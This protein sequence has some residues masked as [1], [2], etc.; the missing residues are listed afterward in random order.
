VTILAT[1]RAGLSSSFFCFPAYPSRYSPLV[2]IRLD[3]KD[4]CHPS[5]PVPTFHYPPLGEHSDC[6]DS[7]LSSPKLG[8]FLCAPTPPS[9]R[10]Q[11]EQPPP[12]SKSKEV[13]SP[14]RF[15]WTFFLIVFDL[16][17]PPSSP[18]ACPTKIFEIQSVEEAWKGLTISFQVFGGVVSL[19][20]IELHGF[21]FPAYAWQ[22]IARGP[23]RLPSGLSLSWPP[24]IQMTLS[25]LLLYATGFSVPSEPFDSFRS[26]PQPRPLQESFFFF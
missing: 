16:F 24:S 15:G 5:F 17:P 4:H 13:A 14:S 19:W 8:S 10:S 26:N 1:L 2:A 7:Y 22:T 9:S 12:L 23:R 20:A 6:E 25:S 11:G 3:T 21:F 18:R